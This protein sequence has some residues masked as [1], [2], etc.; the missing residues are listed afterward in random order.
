M[1]EFDPIAHLDF[2]VP[3]ELASGLDLVKFESFEGK[4]IQLLQK[5]VDHVYAL[6]A[7]YGRAYL[8]DE[9]AYVDRLM[10]LETLMRPDMATFGLERD[11]LVE[12]KVP[13]IIYPAGFVAEFDAGES[14]RARF[15][16]LAIY[17]HYALA[18]DGELA[19]ALPFGMNMSVVEPV[20]I[21]RDKTITSLE[22]VGDVNPLISLHHSTID[23]RR[24]ILAA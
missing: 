4:R 17:S 16:G 11:D 19:E 22:G 5:F 1:S 6:D 24:V 18:R 21:G 9:E 20:A 3:D 13:N 15:D 8:A 10:Q 12:V 23:L 2:P 14:V 7:K